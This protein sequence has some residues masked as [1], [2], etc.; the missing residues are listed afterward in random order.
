MTIRT[1]NSAALCRNSDCFVN[2]GHSLRQRV[3]Q[4][5]TGR[6]QPLRVAY[7]SGLAVKMTFGA[8]VDRA[9]RTMFCHVNGR[10]YATRRV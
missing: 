10:P 6:R 9:L 4:T 7:C 5:E 8:V 1:T 3:Q 2:G